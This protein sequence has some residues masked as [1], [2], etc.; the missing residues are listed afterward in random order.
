MALEAEIVKAELDNMVVL[1]EMDANSKLGPELI[2]NDPH[3]QTPNGKLL[4]GIIG[5]HGL[6]VINGLENK[7]VGNITRRRETKDRIELKGAL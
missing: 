7:C 4:S 1:I 5:I 2:K 3:S 6:L